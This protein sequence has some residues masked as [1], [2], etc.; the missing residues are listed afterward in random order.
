MNKTF[1]VILTAAMVLTIMAPVAM[2]DDKIDL[3]VAAPGSG[4]TPV[5]RQNMP[6]YLDS[7]LASKHADF[8]LFAKAKL[9]SFDRNHQ[10]SKSRMQVVRQPDGSY[11]GRYRAADHESMICQVKRSKSKSS[12]YIGVLR[13]YE[14]TYEAVA[15]TPHGV[16]NADFQPV[17]KKRSRHIFS[18]VNGRWQ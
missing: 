17:K 12:P 15:T 13:Y 1:F 8:T 14:M 2:A 6:Q 9:K 5:T 4:N 7:D 11:L 18:F 10:Q 16:R 3:A